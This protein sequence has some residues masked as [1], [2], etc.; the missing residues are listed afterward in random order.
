M[1]DNLHLRLRIRYHQNLDNSFQKNHYLH[2][3]SC[4]MCLLLPD[5][6]RY[7][8]TVCEETVLEKSVQ[9]YRYPWLSWSITASILKRYVPDHI[10]LNTI[11]LDRWR[12]L[13]SRAHLT[14]LFAKQD[15]LSDPG[16]PNIPFD[17]V[18]IIKRLSVGGS[19]IVWK[20]LLSLVRMYSGN[21]SCSYCS[22]E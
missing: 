13:A 7:C 18:K 8:G 15:I 12:S 9:V 20:G 2:L 11:A 16:I 1:L 5:Y 19:G 10:R 22:W 3:A 17:S 21:Q 14:P 4:T 6:H